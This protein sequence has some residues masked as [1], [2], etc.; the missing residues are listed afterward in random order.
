MTSRRIL[1]RHREKIPPRRLRGQEKGRWREMDRKYPAHVPDNW[2]YGDFE[3]TGEETNKIIEEIM[4]ILIKQKITIK[5]AKNIL[6]DTMNA[7]DKEAVLGDR[8]VD[9]KIIPS[10]QPLEDGKKNE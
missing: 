2:L 4:A 7:I 6:E 8:K 3:I 1:S 5:T 10:D 9:G